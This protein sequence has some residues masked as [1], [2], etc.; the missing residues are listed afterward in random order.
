MKLIRRIILYSVLLLCINTAFGQTN[1]VDYDV[2]SYPKYVNG[3]T[4]S[5]ADT[6]FYTF[7]WNATAW[8]FTSLK[9]T[10][11]SGLNFGNHFFRGLL[12]YL[13]AGYNS[14]NTSVKYPLIIFFH[15]G[16]SA[17][18][19]SAAQLC[20]LFKDRGGD[21]ATHLS[22]PGRV[23]RQTSLFTQS[24]LGQTHQYMVVSPQFNNYVRIYPE[25]T[26]NPNK[27]P[28]A[29]EVEKV[30]NYLVDTLYKDKVDP[31]R[32]YLV[33][34]STGAN[35]IME[36]VGSSVARAKRV[37]AVM[38]VSLCS[39]LNHFSNVNIGVS[40]ANIAQ[41]KLKTWFVYCTVDNC[42]SGPALNVSKEWV[43]GINN[44]GGERPRF[45]VLT[46]V[47]PRITNSEGL[48]NCSDTLAHDAWSRAFDPNFQ[49]S[50]TGNGYTT[51][52][53]D[54]INKNIYQWFTQQ[55][56]AVL[57]VTLTSFTAHLLNKNVEL[58]WTTSDE[59][60][61]AS[62]T[63]ER[64]GTDQQFTTIGTI[65]GSVN[66][67]GEKNYSFT[68]TDPL[69]GLGFYRL[70]QTDIDGQKTY[71]QIKKILNRNDKG[72][73]ALIYPNPFSSEISVL[74]SLT[75]SQKV[76]LSVTDMSGK[77]IRTISGVYAQGSSEV[78]I[79][80]AD[81]TKGIYFLKIQGTDFNFMKK[82]VKQ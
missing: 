60:D 82:I 50:F 53:N 76:L 54:G 39:Q 10:K 75:R 70:V 7:N 29:L 13:P 52:T 14:A 4:Q 57:P 12:Q 63:I 25:Q 43:D 2:A 15:G 56:S 16:A 32:I 77:T 45:T 55:I 22:I 37:A 49:A 64:A 72:E 67:V 61:N 5:G 19:G 51:G 1:C 18:D 26:G 23:E 33:G 42:G 79:P 35:M 59:K 80:S 34:Y 21:M 65:P 62:F 71:L 6:T 41:A 58:N 40:T 17:G 3:K 30:I 8:N 81:L 66:S 31:R 24:Y 28:S 46:R 69:S 68:D 48:Y 38:P 11:H 36:Y 78:R 20:R 73:Q 74:V 9:E 44:A 47:T 27:F